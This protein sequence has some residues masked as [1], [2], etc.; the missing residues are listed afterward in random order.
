MHWFQINRGRL[1]GTLARGELLVV[2][3]LATMKS[4]YFTWLS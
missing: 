2:S 3:F 1:F 4:M